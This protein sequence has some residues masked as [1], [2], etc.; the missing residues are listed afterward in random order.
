MSGRATQ[1]TATL[2]AS[3]AAFPEEHVGAFLRALSAEI[4]A[5]FGAGPH[6]ADSAFTTA[7]TR[8]TNDVVQRYAPETAV[9]IVRVGPCGEMKLKL[10]EKE[11]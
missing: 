7:V 1:I 11:I 6:F 4:E 5:A 10:V 9:R 2:D 8:I 3:A